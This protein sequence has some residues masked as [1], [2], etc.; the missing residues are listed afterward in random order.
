MYLDSDLPT[1]EQGPPLA[2]LRGVMESEIQACEKDGTDGQFEF[3]PV[4][5]GLLQR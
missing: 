3:R 4:S 5:V 1:P 2:L